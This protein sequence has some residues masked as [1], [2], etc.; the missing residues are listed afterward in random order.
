LHASVVGKKNLSFTAAIGNLKSGKQNNS[1]MLASRLGGGG[2]GGGH[3][4][5]VF[6]WSL[7]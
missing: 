6:I 4:S 3:F 5:D 2:V 7:L 1:E